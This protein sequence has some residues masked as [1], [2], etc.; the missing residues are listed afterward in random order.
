MSEPLCVCEVGL[1]D[2]LQ[3]LPQLVSTADKQRLLSALL[4]AG[5]Q[6]L[7]L[8]S[9]V[10]P[11]AV[12]Q[13]ADAEAMMGA[14][15]GISGLDARVVVINEKGY[16][17]AIAAGAH[18][19]ALVLA[20][21]ETFS[22]KNNRMSVLDT[23]T[24]VQHLVRRAKAEKHRVRVYLATAWVCPYEGA[25]SETAVLRLAE[26][27]AQDLPDEVAIA[28]TIGHA[29]PTE[30]K[31]RLEQLARI[32][33]LSKLA[34]HFHDTQA[35]GLANCF[36]ALD[37]GVR[38]ID[39]AIAGLGGCPFAPGAAGNLATEDLVFLADKMGFRTGIDHARLLE[40]VRLA[41]A[42]LGQKLGGRT[43]HATTSACAA[44][45]VQGK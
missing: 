41:E 34:V 13:M 6:T 19:L 44:P 38:T 42:I 5:V 43:L 27:L 21:S 3:N 37:V 11:K 25:V 39:S 40:A 2:G 32:I 23:L 16:D 28:D 22:Q 36:A 33:P 45:Y 31:A 18:S 26:M 15:A 12:P 4:S 1:R 30:V 10:S 24:T 35:L 9:F 17:R 8:T 29:H 7:E 14:A 20:C